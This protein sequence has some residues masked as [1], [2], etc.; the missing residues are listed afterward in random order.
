M[1][2]WA[3]A[4]LTMLRILDLFEVDAVCSSRMLTTMDIG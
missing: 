2:T 1:Q 4:R 3:G